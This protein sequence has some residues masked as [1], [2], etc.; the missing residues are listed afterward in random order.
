MVCMRYNH[1]LQCQ[2]L[3][4]ILFQTLLCSQTL[5]GFI[6]AFKITRLH[7]NKHILK[8]FYYVCVSLRSA[9]SGT[10]NISVTINPA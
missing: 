6:N 3:N 2:T 9:D 10:N 4:D 1:R 8:A 5:G 7:I